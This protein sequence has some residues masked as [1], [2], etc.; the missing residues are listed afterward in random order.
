MVDGAMFGLALAV[1][2]MTY[3]S[4][5]TIQVL[6]VP[7]SLR[8]YGPM[9]M[10]DGVVA[11]AATLSVGLV[12]ILVQWVS[13]LLRESLG[14]PFTSST[15]EI[16]IIVAQ[17]ASLD[18]GLFLLISALSTSTVMAPA[19]S[20]LSS[21]LGPLLT[22]VTVALIVWVMV[23]AILGFLPTLW[24]TLYTTGVIFLGI[25]FRIGRRLGTTMMAAS[26]TLMVMLPFMAPLALWLEGHLGY[27]A[28]I[29]PI[30]NIIEQSRSNPLALLRRVPQ[31]P[32]SL[33]ALMVSVIMALV[34]FPFAYFFIISMV[35][36]SLASLLGSNAAGPSISSFVLTP[37][38]E[39]GSRLSK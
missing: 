38:W 35:A 9:L 33:A 32:I 16:T 18:A 23:Q 30:E 12:Q 19:A 31:L 39:T 29:R 14:P 3:M 37:A 7:R 6:P 13:N 10:W 11:Q 1:A 28:A 15:N 36:R 25:P 27:T 4:G 24:L 26:I 21:M 2:M 34:I 5:A 20:A 22:W 8:S 17:L